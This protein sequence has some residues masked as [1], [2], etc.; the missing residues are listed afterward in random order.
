MTAVVAGA[1]RHGRHGYRQIA[2]LRLS[3]SGRVVNDKQVARQGRGKA[4]RQ[5]KRDRLWLNDG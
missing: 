2:E 3:R 4:D 5:P 1:L